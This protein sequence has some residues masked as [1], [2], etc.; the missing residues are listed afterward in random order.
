RWGEEGEG[1]ALELAPADGEPNVYQTTFRPEK[2]RRLKLHL[3]DDAGRKN[4]QI[5]ELAIHVVPNQA[6]VLKPIFPARDMEV[7]ALEELDLKF[8]AFDDFGL[9]RAGVSYGLA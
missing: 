4:S 1:A 6:P 5:S 2:S 3:I 9:I 7:S 8:T